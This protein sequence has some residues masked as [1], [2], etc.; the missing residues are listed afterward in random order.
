MTCSIQPRACRTSFPASQYSFQ[1][2][3]A[4]VWK[5]TKFKQVRIIIV[6]FLELVTALFGAIL[7]GYLLLIARVP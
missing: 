4:T 7:A 1:R 3:V 2:S 5:P 6:V